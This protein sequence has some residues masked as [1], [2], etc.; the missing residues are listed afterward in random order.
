MIDVIRQD[1][2][3]LVFEDLIKIGDISATAVVRGDDELIYAGGIQFLSDLSFFS[4]AIGR[5][6][7]E[8]HLTKNSSSRSYF[9]ISSNESS[10]VIYLDELDAEAKKFCRHFSPLSL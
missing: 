5:L 4:P 3:K 7:I 9:F 8:D 1:F 6:K 10:P 2:S